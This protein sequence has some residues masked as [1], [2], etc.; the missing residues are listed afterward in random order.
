MYVMLLAEN[1]QYGKEIEYGLLDRKQK[2]IEEK[3]STTTTTK[4]K[5]TQKAL[6][7]KHLFLLR[8]NMLHNISYQKVNLKNAKTRHAFVGYIYCVMVL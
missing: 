2:P 6:V 7:Q 3:S 8:G 4:I 1:G 5:I